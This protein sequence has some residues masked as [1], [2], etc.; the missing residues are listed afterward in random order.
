M[1]IVIDIQGCQT[2]GR[3][4]G[5]GRYTVGLVRHIIK[6]RGEHEV[7]LAA[8]GHFRDT[9]DD[10]R[11]CFYG[12]IDE[13]AL[14][15]WDCCR[16]NGEDDALDGLL[17]E[18][19]IRSLQPDILLITGLFERDAVL[20][21]R[22]YAD[23]PVAALFYDAIPIIHKTYYLAEDR[24]YVRH[25]RRLHMLK[26]ADLVL[27]ASEAARQDHL[28][29]AD[30]RADRTVALPAAV[31]AA[32]ASSAVSLDEGAI[33]GIC[34]RNAIAKPFILGMGGDW[35]KNVEGLITAFSL[36][37]PA[38]REQY[39]LVVAGIDDPREKASL[40]R[41]A[42]SWGL[43]EHETRLLGYLPESD[44]KALYRAC[45]IAAFPSFCEGFGLSLLEAMACGAPAIASSSPALREVMD[46]EEALF[47]A[48]NPRSLADKL[49]RALTEEAFR[50][51][52]IRHG[53]RRARAFSWD[54]T[55]RKAI[56]ALE[57][58]VARPRPKRL[59]LA[60]IS[61]FPPEKSGI[62]FYSAELVPELEKHYDVVCVVLDENAALRE[63]ITL[64]FRSVSWFE[65]HFREFDRVLYHFGNSEFHIH[66]FDLLRRFPGVA[67]LHDFFLSGAHLAREAFAGLPAA[68]SR[69][70]FHA[71]GYAAL[72]T[73]YEDGAH[74][75]MM[76]YPVCASVI[77]QSLGVISHSRYSR[78]LARTW[79]GEDYA[80]QWRVI[81]LLQREN[82]RPADNRALRESLS[83]GKDT[84]VICSFGF[85]TST[86]KNGALIEGWLA[87]QL[88]EHE[89]TLLVFVG[90]HTD[91]NNKARMDKLLS[92]R[93][94]KERVRVTG[95][96]S[97]EDFEAYMKVCDVAV[98]L[99]TASRG[100]TSAAILT[101]LSYGIP[102]ITNKN[103]SFAE[104]PEDTVIMLEDDFHPRE[105]AQAL[106]TL[107]KDHGKR[108]RLG[109]RG[110][111]Y[112]RETHSPAFCAAEYEK[113]LEAF[114]E[115]FRPL[116]ECLPRLCA[117]SPGCSEAQLKCL[118]RT[119]SR[120][121]P[122]PRR[123]KRLF[124]DVSAIV[125]TD[126]RTGIQRVT[127]GIL[128]EWLQTPPPGWV[129]CP[130]YANGE[131]LG[132]RHAHAWMRD[133]F[134]Y[135][136][137]FPQD[138]FIDYA[139]GDLFLGL[140]LHQYVVPAQLEALK[141]MRNAGVRVHFVLYDLLPMQFPQ[142]FPEGMN[143][144]HEQWLKLICGFDG[145]MCISR[146]VLQELAAW[147]EK[148]GP[149][150]RPLSAGWFHIG[151]DIENSQP[152][153]GL[154]PDGE[155]TLKTL[156]R[157]PCVLMVS[158][159]EP[160]KGYGQALD[161]FELLWA[162][163]HNVRLVMVGKRGWNV[164]PLVK[165]MA[166]HKERGNRFFWLEGVSD[167]YLNKLY[168]AANVVL[169]ASEGEGFGL[170]IVEGARHGKPLILRDLPV[171]REIAGKHAYYFRGDSPE[172]LAK[173]VREWFSLRAA[174]R[175]PS[176]QGIKA[177][178]W[179]ESADM[180]RDRLAL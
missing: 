66:M 119:L 129:V 1:R 20:S 33:K 138:D 48:G 59:K 45:R 67:V 85:L 96:A 8:N 108:K 107:W 158:T 53:A 62:S 92:N 143:D 153:R 123:Q 19:F 130:V 34:R 177:L 172:A 7:L 76:R 88:A 144:V 174:R 101:A 55:A 99:R 72:R 141:S 175:V 78:Q 114:Y 90:E 128:G 44:L 5:V 149:Q 132:Y 11:D 26:K 105:L 51:R 80:R 4:R 49:L 157:G 38:L 18:Y 57:E 24:E 71:H 173:A 163:G 64:S 120:L 39:Q 74:E 139:C 135:W 58:T 133:T 41:H 43:R 36:L 106:N 170:A 118:S 113:A 112:V 167:E 47:D 65:E 87:S 12:C 121:F 169:M 89:D 165:R 25:A 178:T 29:Y 155:A 83:I 150:R 16:A 136:N 124:V 84:F 156:G 147:H 145:V 111:R 79:Y 104:L 61:P 50:Q 91:P 15:I 160:R 168:A 102:T 46:C 151:C 2:A 28:R 75:A 142:Y 3:L 30:G 60:Y 31:E 131:S 125:V 109:E 81:P 161:A 77:E 126:I 127:R 14:K 146:S 137:P 98:Q 166:T 13:S 179:K 97:H 122:Q 42:E 23:T 82:E 93:R 32:F 162:Q 10:I 152:S 176:S 171:F 70:L 86:K 94:D 52:L 140:D 148:N 134:G 37:P 40:R 103:G 154:P 6:N 35:R 17:Y 56:R 21:V 22:A 73:L 159:I 180:L 164:E 116:H 100:E 117:A 95:W 69:E 110:L 68:F 63:H 54:E 27:A 115:T 9:L